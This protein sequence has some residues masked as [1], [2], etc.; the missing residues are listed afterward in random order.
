MY[1]LFL[2][3]CGAIVRVEV[4]KKLASCVISLFNFFCK[5]FWKTKSF[6]IIV[7]PWTMLSV[8]FH[9]S[10]FLVSIEVE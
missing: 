3:V 9:I 5:I 8:N 6:G 2:R 4:K 10:T 7:T 1:M